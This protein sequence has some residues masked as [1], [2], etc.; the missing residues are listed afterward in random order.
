M[1]GLE[2]EDRALLHALL[3]R[4]SSIDKAEVKRLLHRHHEHLLRTLETQASPDRPGTGTSKQPAF[5]ARPRDGPS[6][7]DAAV[8]AAATLLQTD[9]RAAGQM[10]QLL[11]RSAYNDVQA[12]TKAT[13]AAPAASQALLEAELSLLRHVHEQRCLLLR[14]VHQLLVIAYD[15]AAE[16]HTVACGQVALLL[17]GQL[18]QRI[19][20]LVPLLGR[21]TKDSLEARLPQRFL[22]AA[23]D[24]ATKQ[25]WLK[26]VGETLATHAARERCAP[27]PHPSTPHLPHLIAHPSSQPTAPP[28][29]VLT[30]R[31]P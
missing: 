22:G 10:V 19:I 9:E 24:D 29:G 7:S 16:L 12:L 30:C 5:P 28:R 15:A 4:D 3:V 31:P 1:S 25:Q 13:A 11:K 27:T 23:A 6:P 2:V 26:A 8:N 21:P 20:N 18:P 17:E 14:C